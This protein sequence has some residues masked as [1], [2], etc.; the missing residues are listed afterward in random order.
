MR[1][2]LWVE[3]T[4]SLSKRVNSFPPIKVDDKYGIGGHWLWQRETSDEKGRKLL[5]AAVS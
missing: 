5:D 4:F 3:K 1:S 2:A